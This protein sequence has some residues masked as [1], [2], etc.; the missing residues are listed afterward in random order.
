MGIGKVT[1]RGARGRGETWRR[2]TK[3]LR[4]EEIERLRDIEK[5]G[6]PLPIV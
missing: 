6:V 3:G 5:K 2:E 1:E 4:D